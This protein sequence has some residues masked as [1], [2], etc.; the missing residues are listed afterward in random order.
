MLPVWFS[1]PKQQKNFEPDTKFIFLYV[2]V[3]FIWLSFISFFP[4]ISS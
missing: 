3:E 1:L 2:G 4:L